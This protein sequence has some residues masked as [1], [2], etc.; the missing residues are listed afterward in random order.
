VPVKD[1]GLTCCK[2]ACSTSK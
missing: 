1:D 2:S